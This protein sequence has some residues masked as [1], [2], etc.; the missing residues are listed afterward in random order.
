MLTGRHI[1]CIS[2]IDWDFI[3]QGHQEIMSRLAA[4]GNVV[5][6]VENTGVRPPRFTDLPRLRHRLRNW[7][8]GVKGFRQELEN[9]VVY[10]PLVL[11]FPYSRLAR[12]LNRFVLLRSIRRWMRAAHAARPI[13]WTFLPTPMA[14]D[15]IRAL[16][17]ALTVY[18][19]IDDFTSSS[20]AARRIA[21][22]ENRLFAEADLVF[23]TSERLRERAARSG[24][25][26]DLFPFGVKFEAFEAV[27]ESG[28]PPPAEVRDLPRP[29]VGYVGGIHR[30]VDQ[31]L[32]AETA[33]RLPDASFVLV[34]PL[35]TETARL[36]ARPNVHLL[37]G[38]RHEDVP[39]Y[40]GAFDVG[41]VPYRLSEYTAN[42]YPTKLNEYLAMGKPVVATDLLEIRR[43]NAEHGAVV[44]VATGAEAFADAIRQAVAKAAPDVE[45]RRIAAARANGWTA[46]IDRMSTLIEQALA[47]RRAA[48]ARWPEILRRSYR[49]ARRR[50]AAGLLALLGSYLLVFET[51]IVWW[52]AEPLR[53]SE[54]PRAADA[55]VVFAGGVGESGKPGGG[56]QE[57]V[58]LA[59]DLYRRQY[60]GHL[61]F[62]TGYAFA[63][64]EAEV[65][66]ELALAL[67]VPEA[68]IV[69]E[70]QAASTYENVVFVTRILEQHGWRSALLVTSPYHT[71][72]ALLT[73]RT[74]APGIAVVP[75]PVP[76]S[77]FYVRGRGPSL[78]QIRGL[79]QEAAAI[80][81]YWWRGWISV[82]A[83]GRD[84]V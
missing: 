2:S 49:H 3:W 47:R 84:R 40:V 67:G 71:R 13:A 83:R 76:E 39:R 17:P 43:F 29:I 24:R 16:D 42:V 38:R 68:A 35:Q 33:A 41:L 57:R 20:A 77:Q 50:L 4:A 8:R 10:S 46:R 55:I 59:V 48:D 32:L 53:V 21:A 25:H 44:A 69:L 82:T 45:A 54:A 58:K 14:R 80:V 22:S 11:P 31:E 9:L 70:T 34:G 60:A 27:R 15:L 56:Y 73:W 26:V 66:R 65:M 78:E 37:G 52:A 19:C 75:A 62:S 36:A 5:L 1:I 72:R 51:P 12:R 28:E 79:A 61:V 23:V 64:P 81:V 30:W 63:F 6:F 18:Y 7:A 74:Q